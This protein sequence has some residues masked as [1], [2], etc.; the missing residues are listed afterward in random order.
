MEL[1]VRQIY[2]Q[3]Y[4]PLGLPDDKRKLMSEKE[5]ANLI[6]AGY[7]KSAFSRLQSLCEIILSLRRESL[8]AHAQNADGSNKVGVTEDD[9]KKGRG[10]FADAFSEAIAALQNPANRPPASPGTNAPHGSSSP[11]PTS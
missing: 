1:L 6:S 4:V 11:Q 2:R 7:F 3:A 5:Y 10:Y 9:A 8:V